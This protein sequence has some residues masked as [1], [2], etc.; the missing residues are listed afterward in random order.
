[1]PAILQS[2]CVCLFQNPT[3]NLYQC[4]CK[5]TGYA[6]QIPIKQNLPLSWVLSG[7]QQKLTLKIYSESFRRW[8]VLDATQNAIPANIRRSC[9]NEHSAPSHNGFRFLLAKQMIYSCS[10]L[11][12]GK[13]TMHK[14]SDLQGSGTDTGQQLHNFP[15]KLLLLKR[16]CNF[17]SVCP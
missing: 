2:T 14:I 3:A 6:L 5:D 10:S 7:H 17:T 12:G 4:R 11:R 13:H 9:L 15:A 8:S 16:G 1:M